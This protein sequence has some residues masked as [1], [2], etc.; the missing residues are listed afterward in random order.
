MD[1][2]WLLWW[3]VVFGTLAALIGP[4]KGYSPLGA[5]TIGA[6]FGIFGVAFLA[7]REDV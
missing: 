2:T 4:R 3:V 6:I 5:F 1:W 7:L